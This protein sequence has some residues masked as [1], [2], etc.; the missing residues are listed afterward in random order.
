D[1]Y[2]GEWRN[3]LMHGRGIFYIA[4]GGRYEG[5]FKNG[6]ATGGWYYLPEGDR[7]RAYMDSEGQWMIE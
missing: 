6:R 2:E 1:R 4:H 7:R 5:E 3:G